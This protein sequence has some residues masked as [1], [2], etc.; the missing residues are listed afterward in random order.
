MIRVVT[1]HKLASA[2][3]VSALIGVALGAYLGP[4]GARART[5][6]EAFSGPVFGAKPPSAEQSAALADGVVTEQEVRSALDR[7]A[8]CLEAYGIRA[9]R[10]GDPQLEGNFQLARFIPDGQ[11]PSVGSDV[12]A[13]CAEEHSAYVTSKYQVQLEEA[14]LAHPPKPR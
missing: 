2:V 9:V 6:S 13:A 1:R 8:D 11:D 7:A 4:L 12:M 5:Q 3:L 10:V 14:G